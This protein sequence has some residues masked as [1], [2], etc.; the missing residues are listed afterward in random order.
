MQ[1][2]QVACALGCALRCLLGCALVRPLGCALGCALGRRLPSAAQLLG[3]CRPDVCQHGGQLLQQRRL[4]R[5]IRPHQLGV[6]QQ[7]ACPCAGTRAAVEWL[8][9]TLPDCLPGCVQQRLRLR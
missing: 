4:H 3:S 2:L 5:R 1:E 8:L 7:V 9:L 6:Q